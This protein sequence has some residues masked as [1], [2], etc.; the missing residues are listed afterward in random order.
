M[1]NTVQPDV[2]E[3]TAARLETTLPLGLKLLSNGRAT[4]QFGHFAI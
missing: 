4:C 3:C 1:F 2:Y